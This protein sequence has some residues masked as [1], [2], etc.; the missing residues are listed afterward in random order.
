MT[1]RPTPNDTAPMQR[2]TG[3]LSLIVGLVA[4]GAALWWLQT[5]HAAGPSGPPVM[6]DR[7]DSA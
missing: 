2:L 7:P 1:P 3:L 4:M 5:D 6:L